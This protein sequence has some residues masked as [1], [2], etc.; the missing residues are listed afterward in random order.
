MILTVLLPIAAIIAFAYTYKK[1]KDL[2][3]S[4]KQTAIVTIASFALFLITINAIDPNSTKALLYGVLG[5]RMH[6]N[7]TVLKT[8]VFSF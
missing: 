1:T 5:N 3:Q 6:T 4:L 8:V 7:T 2:A